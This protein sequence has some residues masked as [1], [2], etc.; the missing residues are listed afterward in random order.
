[1][2]EELGIMAKKS[3][4]FDEW[5]VQIIL[6]SEFADYSDVSGCLILRPDAYFVWEQIQKYTDEEFKKIGIKNVYFPLFIP[7]KLLNKEK[8]HVE[9]FNP[10]VACRQQQAGVEA[11]C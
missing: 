8:E 3:D 10:E 2:S 1:M 5:Y 6:R 4:N 7:E 9:G 11:G